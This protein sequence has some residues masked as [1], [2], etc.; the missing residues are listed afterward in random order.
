MAKVTLYLTSSLGESAQVE[1]ICFRSGHSSVITSRGP[2]W[3]TRSLTT[4]RVATMYRIKR[5]LTYFLFSQTDIR[6]Y[7]YKEILKNSYLHVCMLCNL[8]Q[9]F[10]Y[11]LA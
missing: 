9:T 10:E 5:I 7:L 8:N 11:I 1:K 3:V 6:E 2:A 4:I